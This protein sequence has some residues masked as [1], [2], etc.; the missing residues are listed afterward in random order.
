L[1]GIGHTSVLYTDQDGRRDRVNA[2]SARM[3]TSRI[4]IN[5]PSSQG[6][7]GD[8]YNFS[9]APSLTLGCG[10]WGG[11]SVTV[12]VGPQQLLNIKTVAKRAE[13]MLWHKLPP[14][15]YFRRGCLPEAIKELAGKKRA[16]LVTDPY[17]YHHGHADELIAHL[18]HE[19]LEVEVFSQVEADPTLAIVR[20]CT[21]VAAAFRPDVIVAFGGG[22]PMDAAKIAWVLY[23]HPEVDFHSLAMRFMDIRKRIYHFP[24]LG[25]KATL[26]AIPTTSGTGSEVTPFAVVTDDATGKKYPIADYELT[27]RM[28][29][30]DPNLVMN[31]PKPLTAFGGID[32]VTHSL[33]SYVSIMATEFTDG[34]ALQALKLLKDYLPHAYQRGASDPMA[35]EKVH[36]AA[37]IAGMAFANAFLGVCHSMAHKLGAEFHLPHGLAIGLLVANVV[38]YNANDNPTKQSAFSQYDRPKA[39]CRYAEIAESF[40][41]GGRDN[42]E[43]VERLIVWIE[44]LKRD[45]EIPISIQ[46]A[47]VPEADFLGRLDH[48]A[49]ESFDDQCTGANPRYPLI[50]ELRSILLDSYY[51]R[52]FIEF[53]GRDLSQTLIAPGKD[54]TTC[55]LE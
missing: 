15:I 10:S 29:I 3:K 36:Y 20:K 38:R 35:R 42:D 40:G 48:I 44:D 11:N 55:A 12:N 21:E 28:A 25:S 1:E 53:A 6:G 22:S 45:L 9:L 51:G 43:K 49:I 54:S 16:L 18:K 23:E 19:G 8:L 7:I 31:L 27:P 52:P 30:I 46:A 24:K 5:T 17:L 41:L 14:S 4:L 13:N 32:A 47:G 39:R 34:Q 33:E 26:V 2:F 37:T 50:D